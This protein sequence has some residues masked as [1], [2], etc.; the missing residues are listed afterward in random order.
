LRSHSRRCRILTS[1]DHE[2]IVIAAKQILNS[3]FSILNS[4]R[5]SAAHW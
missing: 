3:Q 5:A 4:R 2:Q 1:L